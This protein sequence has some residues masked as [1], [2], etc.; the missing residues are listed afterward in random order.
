M[1]LP[2]DEY[3]VGAE[4]HADTQEP[5]NVAVDEPRPTWMQPIT[6]CIALVHLD[7]GKNYPIV[8][9]PPSYDTMF[10]KQR[11]SL[12]DGNINNIFANDPWTL[13]MWSYRRYIWARNFNDPAMRYDRS[14]I[15]TRSNDLRRLKELEEENR[16]LKKIVADQVVNIEALKMVADGKF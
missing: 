14:I 8:P 2:E 5:L 3:V 6:Y 16:R 10:A 11:Y 15:N 7:P 13:N 1:V 4:S 12:A 9:K